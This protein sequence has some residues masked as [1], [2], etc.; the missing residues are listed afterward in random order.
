MTS[1]IIASALLGAAFGRF[2]KVWILIPACA[3]AFAIA[4]VRSAYYQLGFLN[5]LFEFA[6][7]AACLQFG[8]ACRCL[9]GVI[10]SRPRRLEIARNLPDPAAPR[11]RQLF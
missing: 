9:S 5:I 10:S 6:G 11:R 2:F 4:A 3:A 7:L 1:L 8:Y